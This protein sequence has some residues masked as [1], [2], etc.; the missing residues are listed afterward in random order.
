MGKS[1]GAPIALDYRN[2]FTNQMLPLAHRGGICSF[3]ENETSTFAVE[4]LIGFQLAYA[5][6]MAEKSGGEPVSGAVLT[7]KKLC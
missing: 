1:F 3:A 5:K 6:H 2:T 4:E 7:V